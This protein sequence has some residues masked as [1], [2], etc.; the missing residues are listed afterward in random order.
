MSTH[1]N[2]KFAGPNVKTEQQDPNHAKAKPYEPV[3][4]PEQRRILA[5][6]YQL[7]L[8]W[9]RERL[10]KAVPVITAGDTNIASAKS[11]QALAVEVEA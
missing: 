10:H 7:I 5:Q 11:A 9:R 3:L 8:S 1:T 4:S 2:K 6:V